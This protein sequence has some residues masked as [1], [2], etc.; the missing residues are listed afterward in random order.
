MY[1][2]KTKTAIKFYEFFDFRNKEHYL[3][4]QN[5]WQEINSDGDL[6]IWVG[7]KFQLVSILSVNANYI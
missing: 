4:I 2:C 7:C 5:M 6:C 3:K 1:C